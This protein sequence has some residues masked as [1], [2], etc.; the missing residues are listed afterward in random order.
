MVV[1]FVWFVSRVKTNFIS[2]SYR[3]L[4]GLYH[5]LVAFPSRLKK[6]K[7]FRHKKLNCEFFQSFHFMALVSLMKKYHKTTYHHRVENDYYS[8]TVGLPLFC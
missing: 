4:L 3:K 5:I 2:K 1:V 8:K 7:R 6:K